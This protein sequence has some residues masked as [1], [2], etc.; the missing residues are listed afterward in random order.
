MISDMMI[1]PGQSPVFNKPADFGLD[2]EDVSFSARDG[3][4]LRGWLIK[5]GTDKI[6]IQSNFGVQCSRAVT[7]RLMFLGF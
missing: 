6:I 5:G 7:H 3:V 1:K 4:T 2:Y